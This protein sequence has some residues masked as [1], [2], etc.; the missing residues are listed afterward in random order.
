MS[1]LDDDMITLKVIGTFLMQDRNANHLSEEDLEKTIKAVDNIKHRL[2][3]YKE[4]RS[5]ESK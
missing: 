3:K 5:G 4:K 1:K 2:N